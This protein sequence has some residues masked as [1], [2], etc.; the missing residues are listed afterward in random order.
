[1]HKLLPIACVGGVRPTPPPEERPRRHGRDTGQ[2]QSLEWN[3]ISTLTCTMTLGRLP[4]FCLSFLTCKMGIRIDPPPRMAI[5]SEGE[6]PPEAPQRPGSGRWVR[7]RTM[8]PWTVSKGSVSSR[9]PGGRTKDLEF[10]KQ[11][12]RGQSGKLQCGRCDLNHRP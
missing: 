8:V 6:M 9:V 2:A 10:R 5:S 12:C 1:M 11:T 4:R 7:L 3:C